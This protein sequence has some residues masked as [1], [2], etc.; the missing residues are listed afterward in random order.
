[1]VDMYHPYLAIFGRGFIN[2]FEVV[3]NNN[4]CAWRYQLLRE[5]LLYS[6][7]SKMPET[8]KRVTPRANQCTSVEFYWRK[9]RTLCRS[10]MRWRK[11]RN[12]SWWWNQKSVLG[13]YAW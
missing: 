8:L 9:N 4:S 5:L 11:N 3:I 10:K 2:K 12:S 1:L 6:V 13:L 7:I